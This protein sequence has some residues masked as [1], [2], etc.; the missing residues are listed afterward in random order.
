M[1]QLLA[2]NM[3]FFKL[4]ATRSALG[5]VEPPIN[6]HPIQ[7][8]WFEASLPYRAHESYERRRD[9]QRS[10]AK[11]LARAFGIWRQAFCC[12]Y[13][14]ETSQILIVNGTGNSPS[15]RAAARAFFDAKIR[16]YATPSPATDQ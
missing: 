12:S 5:C 2:H 15:G 8:Q 9:A 10:A 16:A 14:S 4:G 7:L 13:D 11:N 6:G 1:V 3:R